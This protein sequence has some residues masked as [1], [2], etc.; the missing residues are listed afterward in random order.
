M[1][2]TNGV[3]WTALWVAGGVVLGACA[4]TPPPPIVSPTGIVYEPGTPPEATRRS[5]TAVLYLQQDRTQRALD[6]SLEG[7]E[8]DPQ[9]PVHYYLAGIAHA[10]LGQYVEADRRFSKAQA[11]YP[12]YELDI[13]PYRRASWAEAFNNGVEAYGAG[14]TE[15]AIEEWTKATVIYDLSVEAHRNLASLLTVEGRHQEAIE[16]YR[17]ALAGLEKRPATRVLDASDL[18]ERERERD[19]IEDAL[20]PVLLLTNRFAEAEVLLRRHLE[21]LPGDVEGR[22]DLADALS[23]QGR[24]AEARAI[25]VELLSEEGLQATQLFNL[26]VALFRTR[27]FAGAASA[28]QRLTGLQPESRDAWFNYANALFA[29]EDWP[30]LAAA[31]GRLVELD[32]LGE[33]AGLI[34]ARAHLESGDRPTALQTLERARAAPV[35]I[36]ELQMRRAGG[37]TTVHGRITGNRAQAGNPVRLRFVFYGEKGVL[38]GSKAL[39]MPAPPEGES[40]RFA[41]QFGMSAMAYHY[42]QMN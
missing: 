4:T 38:L 1:V 5:Q 34:T 13:E 24:E 37:E 32:P 2:A 36:D 39:S 23:G 16:V 40:E 3:R 35:Y 17:E 26:G 33:N 27:D 8:S 14:D 15:N 41:V 7:I 25:Y 30:A 11:L 28:F 21:R 20:S 9:N 10:R 12:A 42:E 18:E 6:L 22:A 31:G 19:R 29:A